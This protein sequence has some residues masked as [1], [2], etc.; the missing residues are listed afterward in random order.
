MDDEKAHRFQVGWESTDGESA[1][2]KK[3][4]VPRRRR[5]AT[6]KAAASADDK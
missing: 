5:P 4:A 1:P 3:K 6:E 2:V